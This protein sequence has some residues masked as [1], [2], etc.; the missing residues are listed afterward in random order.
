MTQPG[1]AD[2]FADAQSF[3]AGSQCIDVT[4]DL[5]PGNDGYLRE[6][7]LAVGHMQIGAADATGSDR[8]SD[9]P[10]PGLAVRELGPIAWLAD[11]VQHHGVHGVP[12]R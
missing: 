10:G 3:D 8:D 11:L 9:L 7:Q 12:F 4:D 2:A 6:R 1:G 5:V